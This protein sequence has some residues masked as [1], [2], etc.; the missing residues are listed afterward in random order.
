M[1]V[2][3]DMRRR[4]TNEWG[5]GGP[6]RP[7]QRKPWRAYAGVFLMIIAMIFFANRL[8]GSKTKKSEV[9]KNDANVSLDVGGAHSDVSLD[10]FLSGQTVSVPVSRSIV[11]EN[12][13]EI[14]MEANVAQ[15]TEDVRISSQAF[16]AVLVPIAGSHA[17]GAATSDYIDGIFR[18]LVIGTLPDPPEGYFYEGWLVRSRPFD[19]FSTGEFIQ[20]VDDLKWYLVYESDDDKRDYNKVIVTLEPSDNDPAPAEHVLEGVF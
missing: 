5:R 18:H 13:D 11:L 3:S 8:L 10:E 19:F 14:K 1:E 20:H 7:R 16:D 17:D 6:A 15:S 12:A 4:V 9:I 2:M